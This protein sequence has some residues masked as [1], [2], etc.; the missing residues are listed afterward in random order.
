M[1]GRQSEQCCSA[2]RSKLNHVVYYK[3]FGFGG[4]VGYEL[5]I[6]E[7]Q[8]LNVG[9]HADGVRHIFAKKELNVKE[10]TKNVSFPLTSFCLSSSQSLLLTYFHSLVFLSLSLPN[11]SCAIVFFLV[12]CQYV[13]VT[14]SNL[15]W[16]N[17]KVYLHS[18]LGLQQFDF[19]QCYL[20]CIPQ[21]TD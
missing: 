18:T 21:N 10:D 13:S 7:M 11:I 9:V 19:Y 8:S 6:T 15:C 20:L 16:V 1:N 5:S 2:W 12:T 17:Y 3:I 4:A 14:A